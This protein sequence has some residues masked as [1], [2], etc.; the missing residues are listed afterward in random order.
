[1]MSVLVVNPLAY[2]P[3]AFFNLLTPLIA[4]LWAYLNIGQTKLSEDK[5]VNYSLRE[6]P[7]S[8]NPLTK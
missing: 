2:L 1:M 4:L 7:T 6:G 8:R 3:Y 5:G